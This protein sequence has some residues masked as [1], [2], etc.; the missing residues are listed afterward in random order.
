MLA[1]GWRQG[2]D[3]STLRTD[4]HLQKNKAIK[5]YEQDR[6]DG[7]LLHKDPVLKEGPASWQ[8]QTLTAFLL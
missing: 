8:L 5:V 1:E 2:L 7:T 3:V 6:A 4:A